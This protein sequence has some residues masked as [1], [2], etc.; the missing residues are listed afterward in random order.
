MTLGR[1]LG[2]P[3]FRARRRYRSFRVEDPKSARNALR[4]RNEGGR[5]ELRIKGLPRMRFVIRRPLPPLDRLRG[6]R[7]VQK[8][9]RVEV[10]LLFEQD[11]P[12]VRTDAPERPRGLDAGIRSFATLSDGGHVERERQPAVRS[13]IRR[14]QRAVSRSRRGSKSRGTKKAALQRAHERQAELGRQELHRLADQIVKC[15]DFIAVEARQIRNVIGK[16]KNKRG[17][18]RAIAAQ[19]WGEFVDILKF[20][21]RRHSLRRS[22]PG[23]HSPVQGLSPRARGNHP[24]GLRPITRRGS[25]PAGAGEPRSPSDPRRTGWVYPRGRGGTARTARQSSHR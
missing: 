5:G 3:R 6:F 8:A 20:C 9:R 7:V 18:N 12:A 15:T 13:A 11:L 24:V 25:I 21:R 17:L 1:E 2:F 23:I 19:G 16:G 10:Q 4:I 14:K 22:S